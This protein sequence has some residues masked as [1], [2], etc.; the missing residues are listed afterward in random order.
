MKHSLSMIEAFQGDRPSLLVEKKEYGIMVYLT[1]LVQEGND[2]KDRL[3]LEEAGDYFLLH[4][5]T[6]EVILDGE[7]YKYQALEKTA[8]LRCIKITDEDLKKSVSLIDDNIKLVD[9]SKPVYAI[10][11]ITT[12]DD[13]YIPR[14][15]NS[16][17]EYT[18]VS[19]MVLALKRKASIAEMNKEGLP[20]SF[21]SESSSKIFEL[22]LNIGSIDTQVFKFIVD[23]DDM[24][25]VVAISV[26]TAGLG[27]RNIPVYDYRDIEKDNESILISFTDKLEANDK[28]L[29]FKA[30]DEH[31]LSYY[32]LMFVN[33]ISKEVFKNETPAPSTVEYL[34]KIVERIKNTDNLYDSQLQGLVSLIKYSG[35][36][37]SIKVI[38]KFISNMTAEM[39]ESVLQYSIKKR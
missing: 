36:K 15:I 39:D 23:K 24:D 30:D 27:G 35:A 38:H 16:N 5:P 1:N 26:F 34:T 8:T 11:Y 10:Y 32:I 21:V 25:S 33:K 22:F 17:P 13:D 31:T 14:A 3:V 7:N 19:D 29:V 9:P 2:V 20:S 18:T 6:T 4:V 37:D 12:P 28:T